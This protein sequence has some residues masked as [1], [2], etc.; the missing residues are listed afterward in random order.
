MII[1]T[2]EHGREVLGFIRDMTRGYASKSFKYM[3]KDYQAKDKEE[4]KAKLMTLVKLLALTH[5]AG[6][7]GQSR[8]KENSVSVDLLW[9][10][11]V[12]RII[13]AKFD[14]KLRI[15]RMSIFDGRNGRKL[16]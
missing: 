13:E 5:E 8:I 11:G 16:T 7:V 14:G 2:D 3:F 4:I 9:G 15:R 10:D 12:W 6:T 1:I